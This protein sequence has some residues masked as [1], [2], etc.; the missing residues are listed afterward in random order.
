MEAAIQTGK[1]VLVADSAPAT[2]ERLQSMLA[3]H[4]YSVRSADS[5]A[6]A[7]TAFE[8]EPCAVVIVAFKLRD[9]NGLDLIPPLLERAEDT[10]VILVGG[11]SL[12]ATMAALRGNAAD[13]LPRPVSNK[14]LLIALERVARK[15]ELLAARIAHERALAAQLTQLRTSQAQV[16]QAASLAALGRLAGNLAH[17]INNPLTPILGMV[18]LLQDDLPADHIG[19]IY[20]DV[21]GASARRIRDVVRSLRDF[22]RPANH[23]HAPLD[24]G[25]LITDTLLLTEQQLHDR[26]IASVVALPSAPLVVLG[27]AGQLKQALLLLIDNASEA[28]PEGGELNI[29]L[30][31]VAEPADQASTTAERGSRV[32]IA[33]SDT[34]R[35]IAAQQLPYIFEPFYSTKRQVV[36]VGLGLAVANSIVQDHGGMIEVES[37]EGRG[38]VFRIVLPVGE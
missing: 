21:I 18:K 30:S 11:R 6:A 22:A 3:H 35:G 38:S 37:I 14:D 28:M 36:G 32:V 8:I 4:G 24:L 13:Y 19:R 10:S 33:I 23:Q 16:A 34:G 1:Q 15:R 20:A 31:T 25:S 26:M 17:E 9:G 29:R 27:S 2:R 12:K 7:L 5:I